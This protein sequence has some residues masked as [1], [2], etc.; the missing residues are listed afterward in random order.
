MYVAA[1]HGCHCPERGITCTTHVY[2]VTAGPRDTWRGRPG[3]SRRADCWSCSPGQQGRVTRCPDWLSRCT[4]PPPPARPGGRLL[5]R[6]GVLLSW[7][8][9]HY[10]VRGLTRHHELRDLLG[11]VAHPC[12]SHRQ[13]RQG[14][15]V[16]FTIRFSNIISCKSGVAALLLSAVHSKATH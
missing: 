9:Q 11:E 4:P 1:T 14:T 13:A 16:I 2:T 15:V 12:D 7:Q 5:S 8:Q 6:R 10:P 3:L